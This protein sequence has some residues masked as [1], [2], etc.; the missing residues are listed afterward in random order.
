MGFTQRIDTEGAQP[1]DWTALAKGRMESP[2]TMRRLQRSFQLA[3]EAGNIGCFEIDM[4]TG[5]TYGTPVFFQHF[6]LPRDQGCISARELRNHSHPED[7]HLLRQHVEAMTASIDLAS[8]EY[9]IITTSGETRWISVRSRIERDANGRALMSYGVQQDITDRRTAE[10]EVRFIANHDVLTGLANRALF[11]RHLERDCA[12]ASAELPASLLL[13]DLDLFKQVN[14]TLGHPVGDALLKAVASRLKALAPPGALVARLGGD[15]F[16]IW[17]PAGLGGAASS[18]TE[19][20]AALAAKLVNQLARPFLLLGH[21]VE[22]GCSVGWAM[23][24]GDAREPALL[25]R[26]ADLALY[27]VKSAGRCA[28][29]RFDAGMD[30]AARERQL[31]LQ[32]LRRAL[33]VGAL[34]IDYQPLVAASSH[35]V[36]GFEA[37]VRWDRPGHGL[38]SPADFIPLAEDNGLIAAIG[39]WVLQCALREA[40]GWPCG[41]RVAVNLSPRQ[42]EDGDRLVQPVGR[43]LAASGVAPH[44][45]ELEVTESALAQSGDIGL[46]QLH[47]LRSL[48]VR[49]SI[50]DFGTGHSSLSRLLDFPFDSIKVDKSF[51]A[52]LGKDDKAAAL[53]RSI[54]ALARSL[55]VTA[56]AEGVETQ[57]QA[58]LARHDGFSQIQ[59][60]LIS[61]PMPPGAITPFLNGIAESGSMTCQASG[62]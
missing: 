57:E 29:R 4:I 37:L 40:A 33:A 36:E 51:V 49:I 25:M 5:V 6:G 39:E 52:G 19:T 10:D 34:R 55:N 41:M 50:D 13:I 59:G 2:E 38:V 31:M 60:F 14:D 30:S 46:Q 17:L 1:I 18:P 12:V 28:A 22:I 21:V 35:K 16:A 15:E 42:L 27:D 56:V 43:A 32:D 48:G 53:V 3:Q 26:A 45:L 62:D 61:R 24:P 9:R 58:L 11:N 23:A 54:A 8:I 7:R 20:A 47:R 44:R